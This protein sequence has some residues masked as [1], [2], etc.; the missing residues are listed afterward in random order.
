MKENILSGKDPFE[1]VLINDPTEENTRET[2]ESTESGI[3]SMNNQFIDTIKLFISR[4]YP[5]Y[6]LYSTGISL[7]NGYNS[8][9]SVFFFGATDIF[10]AA[11]AALLLG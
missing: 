6:A 4:N 5:A 11:A 9:L 3:G 7:I 10:A 8:F 2:Q 1:G